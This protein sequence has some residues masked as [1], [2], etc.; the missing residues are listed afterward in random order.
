MEMILPPIPFISMNHPPNLDSVGM[1]RNL[2]ADGHL[3]PQFHFG[4][5]IVGIL[6]FGHHS[7]PMQMDLRARQHS[8]G[9]LD[10]IGLFNFSC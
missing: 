7:K 4:C 2:A 10:W 6:N 5:N 1:R 3:H 8:G 9:G